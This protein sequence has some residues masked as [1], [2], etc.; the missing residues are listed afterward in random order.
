[1]ALSA[2]IFEETQMRFS[3]LGVL[4]RSFAAMIL[5]LTLL[6]SLTWGGFIAGDNFSGG[7]WTVIHNG[8]F[9][10]DLSGWGFVGSGGTATPATGNGFNNTNSAALTA[11]TTISNNGFAIVRSTISVLANTDYVLSGYLNG[12]ALT[13][14]D[15]YLDLNDISVAGKQDNGSAGGSGDPTVWVKTGQS[16]FGYVRFN[17]GSTTSLTVRAVRDA[18]WI[19]NPSK[20]WNP[21]GA[22]TNT[23]NALADQAGYVDE[24]GLTLASHFVAPTAVP[25]PSSLACVSGLVAGLSVLS[26]RRR[27][28]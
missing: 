17:T 15:L 4:S 9:T 26:R 11:N 18:N 25:E 2:Y 21:A 23:G 19:N 24:I 22:S 7:N 5:A 16:G 10:T 6:P 3:K 14:G 28:G 12:K 20:L 13:G 1:L 8:Q 27:Q